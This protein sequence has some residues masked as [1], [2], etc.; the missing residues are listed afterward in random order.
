M[1]YV[2]DRTAWP[3]MVALAA[4][5]CTTIEER[6]LPEPCICSPVPGPMA[7]MDYCGGD[8]DCDGTCGGQA[9]VRLVSEFPSSDF[10]SPSIDSRCGAPMAYTLEVGIARCQPVGQTTVNRFIPPSLEELVEATRLQL[11]DK[12]A[13]AAAVACCLDDGD[14]TYALGNYSPMS[15]TGDCGGGFYTVTLWSV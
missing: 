3:T 5:L 15:V 9:W 10:P 8:G 14:L 1:T 11:A 7:I 13:I 12:A 6:G 2:E 4:C